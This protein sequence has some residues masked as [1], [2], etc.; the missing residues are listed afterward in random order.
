MM[1]LLLF[2]FKFHQSLVVIVRSHRNSLDYET[3]SPSTHPSLESDLLSPITSWLTRGHSPEAQLETRSP[4]W[5][6]AMA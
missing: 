6:D 3:P 1:F 5:T 2:C 4:L